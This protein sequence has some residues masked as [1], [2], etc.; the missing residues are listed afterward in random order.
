[1]TGPRV[2]ALGGPGFVGRHGVLALRTLRPDAS[3]VIADRDGDAARRFA[4]E[5][6]DAESIAVDV[7]DRAALDA[8]LA[9][10]DLVMNTVGPY[11]RFGVPILTACLDAG[12]ACIDVCDDPEPTLEMLELDAAA[13]ER[14]VTAIIGMGI[15]PGVT[16]L[17]AMLAI[18]ALDTAPYVATG[19][20]LDAARPETVGREPSAATVHGIEQLTGTIRVR[21]GGAWVDEPPV[22]AE[23]IDYPLVDDAPKQRPTR[24]YTIGHPEPVTLPRVVPTIEDSVNV[25]ITD[26]GTALAMRGLRWVVDRGL[27]SRRR[28]A[29][30]SERAE[31][32]S[33]ADLAAE[34]VIAELDQGARG[35]P[36][37]FAFARGTRDGRPTRAG[38][39]I[40]A[41]PPGGMGGAT[42]IPLAVGASMILDGIATTPG[43]HPPEGILAPGPFFDRLAQL[44]VPQRPNGHTLVRITSSSGG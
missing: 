8:A 33:P 22:R 38:A 36:P 5:L 18:E 30:L 9:N 28:A 10:V 20:S 39:T 41:T 35:I 37:V 6:G 34:D 31:G 17:L 11:F 29:W 15:S 12:R 43:V 42:G 32:S 23:D 16:N 19:W 21:R 14:G 3:F 44:C 7:T 25:M 27:L 2:L 13:R 24:C 1:M 40:T 4:A 26:G